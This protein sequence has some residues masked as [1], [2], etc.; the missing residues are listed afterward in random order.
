MMGAEA[1]AVL[2]KRK[3]LPLKELLLFGFLPSFLKVWLYRKRGFL[4]GK[5]V[6]IGFGSVI[7]G[8]NVQIHDNTKI[9]F[10]TV[11]RAIR[12]TVGRYVHIGSFVYIDTVDLEIGE[13]SEIREY[14]YVAGLKTPESKLKL[15]KRCGIFQYCF[16]NPTKPIVLGDD[17]GIGGLS[18]LFT[19]GSFLSKLEGYPVAF[20]PI[21][22]G[23]NV[24][25]P[26]DVFILPGVTIGD[27]VVVGAGSIINRDI[28]SNCIAAGNP[29]KVVK[30]NS[31]PALSEVKKKAILK[32]IL[33][34]F[35]SHLKHNNFQLSK[36][37]IQDGFS[38]IFKKQGKHQL[39]Y[40]EKYSNFS[41]NVQDSVL[42]LNEKDTR[43]EEIYPRSNMSMII[44]VPEKERMGT[45]L[46]GEEFYRFLS[47]Y[48]IR[49]N[50]LD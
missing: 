46:I 42:I 23:N 22:I 43:I 34:E 50:R 9:G 20:A 39:I 28:P 44:S 24:W 13:D 21:T 11:I 14:V 6:S 15:G 2:I 1:V 35:E 31:P 29:A 3:K 49:C 45:S 19:H 26:W 10:L 7:S 17:C 36:T 47:R 5:N 12:I 4:I 30:E 32:E 40:A 25:V 8:Q 27:N 41:A 37:S 48:G 38:I 33:S 16:L 18:K